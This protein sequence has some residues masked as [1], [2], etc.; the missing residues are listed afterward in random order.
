[1]HDVWKERW[2]VQSTTDASKEYTLA[3]K[4]DG[5]FGCSCPAWKFHKAPKPHCKHL[6]ALLETLASVAKRSRVFLDGE[7]FTVAKYVAVGTAM[8]S[9]S[10]IDRIMGKSSMDMVATVKGEELKVER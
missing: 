10:L 3:R 9:K 7:E 5:T 2:T 4:Q 8:P 1:M 6:I